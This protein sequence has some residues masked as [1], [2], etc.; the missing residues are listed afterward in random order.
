MPSKYVD[1]QINGS[2]NTILWQKNMGWHNHSNWSRPFSRSTAHQKILYYDSGSCY[3]PVLK[4]NY[5]NISD[6][7]KRSSSQLTKLVH[8]YS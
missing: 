4:L 6:S 3:I 2:P 1:K 7:K 8:E 5:S